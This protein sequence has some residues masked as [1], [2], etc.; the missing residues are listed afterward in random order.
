MSAALPAPLPAEMNWW[1]A[2]SDARSGACG[3][4]GLVPGGTS[5]PMHIEAPWWDACWDAFYI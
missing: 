2:R 4:T 3:A 5:A 1:D